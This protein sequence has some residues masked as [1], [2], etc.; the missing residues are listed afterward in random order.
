MVSQ[1]TEQVI[2][3]RFEKTGGVKFI[4]HLDLARTVKSAVRRAGIT[5]AYSHGFN[6]R[7]KLVF[8]LPLS[9]GTESISEYMDMTIRSPGAPEELADR[10]R[11]VLPRGITVTDAYEK[12]ADFNAIGW[13]EYT[14]T[15]K[16]PGA[17]PSDADVIAHLPD[18][19]MPVQ[20]R[21]KSTASG[22]KETDIAPFIKNMDA[23]YREERGEI[24]VTLLLSASKEQYVNP[25]Y[26]VTA[27]KERLSLSLDDPHTEYCSICRRA[28]FL[29][30]GVTPFR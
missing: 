11:G 18:G 17:S 23:V 30:D 26:V 28:M 14:V 4:S 1:A 9:V 13:A 29:S 5:L 8:A 19:P 22:Y 27:I 24:E 15:L 25:E 21:T 12:A 16:Y 2:R 3:F 10:L 20:K 6:P 7:P